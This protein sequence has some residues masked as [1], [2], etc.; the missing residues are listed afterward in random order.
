LKKYDEMTD[1]E[2]KVA[3]R[4]IITS[5]SSEAEVKQ[6][7]RDELGYPYGIALCTK[8]PAD[9]V[10]KQARE[11]VRGLGGLVMKSGAMAMGLMHGH[12]GTIS[13]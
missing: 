13:L 3:A 1:D 5:S 7:L 2:I 9:E 11:L 10:G 8:V 4:H 12:N 6:R